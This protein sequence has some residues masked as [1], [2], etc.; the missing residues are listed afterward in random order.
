MME[1]FSQTGEEIEDRWRRSEYDE[2]AFPGI[3]ATVL[4][5]SDIIDKTDI[6][7]IMRWAL[8]ET[9]LPQ[10]QDLKAA[11]GDP[12][13]TL[14]KAPRFHIDVYYWLEATT[15]IHQHSFCGAFQVLHGSSI[16]SQ[17]RFETN[18]KINFFS[19]IG[20]LELE[21]CEL[22]EIGDIQRIDPGARYIHALF[23]LD[24]P[25]ATIVIRTF[26][27]G[28]DLP[29]FNYYKPGLAVDPFFQ[30]ENLVKK[31]QLVAAAFRAQYPE[32]M[33]MF[34]EL[35]RELDFHSSFEVIEKLRPYL[36]TT[37]I[38]DVFGMGDAEDRFQKVLDV[39]AETHPEFA[40]VLP[41][42]FKHFS[43]TDKLVQLR[44]TVT[45]AEHRFFLALL[46]NVEGRDLIFSLIKDRYPDVDPLEKTVDWVSQMGNTRILHAGVTNALGIEGFTDFDA[47]VL[48][49]ML[50]G[51]SENQ[52]VDSFEGA[53]SNPDMRN[54][55][56]ESINRIRTADIFDPLLP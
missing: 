15:S 16:H 56:E 28:H 2:D 20:S 29:Q 41:G 46:L 13:L 44:S 8:A 32:A 11:F 39:V 14:F 30:E 34:E 45:E 18:R 12:P 21:K 1:V 7:E 17:Y 22:L 51:K 25:S 4:E 50:K 47:V 52:V 10:Q 19:R 53:E 6:W 24:Q 35:L 31:Q 55:I 3:A 49:E 9:Q 33:E 38:K 42:V 23:H 48:E 26:K 36:M 5:E 37:E 40:E 27:S 54:K 43:R